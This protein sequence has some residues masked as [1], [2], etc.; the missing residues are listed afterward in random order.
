MDFFT[1][2]IHHHQD[3]GVLSS[4]LEEIA[5][6]LVAVFTGLFKVLKAMMLKNVPM[7]T[8]NAMRI[9]SAL[10]IITTFKSN[11]NCFGDRLALQN[12]C[13]RYLHFK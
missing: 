11:K 13:M 4:I 10:E 8:E 1:S 9:L 5:E 2:H 3:H 7:N 6:E 12:P